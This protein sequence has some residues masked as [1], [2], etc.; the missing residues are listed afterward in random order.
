MAA[1]WTKGFKNEWILSGSDFMIHKD[2]SD[3]F[4]DI[5]ERGGYIC[6]ARYV[7]VAKS[8]CE[9]LSGMEK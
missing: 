7:G 5:C 8:I 4:W 2:T 3:G 6:T 9:R 1:K